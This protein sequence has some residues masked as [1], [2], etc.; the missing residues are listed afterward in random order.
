MNYGPTPLRPVPPSPPPDLDPQTARSAA[1]RSGSVSASASVAP[2]SRIPVTDLAVRDT[3]RLIAS[4]F[5]S[6][7]TVLSRLSSSKSVVAE[8]MELDDATND[9][10]LGEEGLL[11][12]IGIH[13]LVYGVRYA[14]IVNAAFTHASPAGG[15]FNA[16]TRGAW[17]CAFDRAT[18][19]AEIAYHKLLQLEEV[20][21][22]EEEVSTSDDYLAD[23]TSPFHDLRD[24]ASDPHAEPAFPWPALASPPSSAPSRTTLPALSLTTS[25]RRASTRAVSPALTRSTP[26]P[27]AS[28]PF[29]RYL[30]STP[31]PRCYRRPQQ[32][33]ERLLSRQS[34]GIVYPSV[35]QPGGTCVVCF[36]PALVYNVRRGARLELRLRAG[37]PFSP[38]EA[39]E[40]P[41]PS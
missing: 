32:L 36:R 11:P 1:P 15:R 8:L 30:R 16:P 29:A 17:Y 18:S 3:H 12:G 9:R 26:E 21:W 38:S 14:H 31:I 35:R 7:G 27:L 6:G 24:P 39:R 4:R 33:A 23:L 34:N 5:S 19:L 28:S 20:A 25:H 22:P 41:V 37:R 10:F 2:S 13:E 40:V